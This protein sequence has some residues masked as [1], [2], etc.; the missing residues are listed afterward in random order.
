[1]IRLE[2]KVI[3]LQGTL[4]QSPDAAPMPQIRMIVPGFREQLNQFVFTEFYLVDSSQAAQHFF[5][6]FPI[7]PPSADDDLDRIAQL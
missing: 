7:Q 4:A 5:P 2:Q 3:S 1:M 6:I